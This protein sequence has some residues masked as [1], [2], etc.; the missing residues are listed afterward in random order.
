MVEC[1]STAVPADHV[2]I[3]MVLFDPST[4]TLHASVNLVTGTCRTTE[5]YSSCSLDRVD[6]SE[7]RLLSVFSVGVGESKVVG[8]NVTCVSPSGRVTT[9]TWVVAL[10]TSGEL[11]ARL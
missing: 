2:P 4:D 8:C 5:V 1:Q 9:L 6:S 3:V 10:V 7:G 11:V